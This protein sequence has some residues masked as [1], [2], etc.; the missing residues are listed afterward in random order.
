MI[1]RLLPLEST[2]K[3]VSVISRSDVD[4]EKHLTAMTTADVLIDSSLLEQDTGLHIE[5]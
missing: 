2:K 3:H 1:Q 5:E 4:L